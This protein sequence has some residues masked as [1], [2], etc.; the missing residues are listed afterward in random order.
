MDLPYFVD[1][2]VLL[3]LDGDRGVMAHHVDDHTQTD[4]VGLKAYTTF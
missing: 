3:S 1:L 2:G 4:P